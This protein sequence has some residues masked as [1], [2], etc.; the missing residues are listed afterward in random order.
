MRSISTG[1]AISRRISS[2][3]GV[4]LVDGELGQRLLEGGEGRAAELGKHPRLAG[5]GQRR[6]DADQVVGL[7]PRLQSFTSDGSGSGS[8]LAFRIF[9][10]MVSASSVRLM[11]DMS[12]S[13]DFDI[14]FVPSRKHMTRVA[15]PVIS[16]SGSGKKPSG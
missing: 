14:F 12:D 11:R 1:S 16:G 5:L 4:S 6:V 8:V 10:A 15:G 9:L 13:S 3:I 2:P 7:G